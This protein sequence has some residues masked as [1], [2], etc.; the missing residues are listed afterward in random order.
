M[1]SEGE[2]R[3]QNELCDMWDLKEQSKETTIAQKQQKTKL[4]VSRKFGWGW[5]GAM[6]RQWLE[7][8]QHSGEGCSVGII[9]P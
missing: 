5:V 1:K 7:G 2:G 8:N 9:C 6:L 3:E 4:A